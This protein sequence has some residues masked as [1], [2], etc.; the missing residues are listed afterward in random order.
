MLWLILPSARERRQRCRDSDAAQTA[1]GMRGLR[2]REPSRDDG[3]RRPTA[4]RCPPGS[5][6]L[7]IRATGTAL[8]SF[9]LCLPHAFAHVKAA[10][11]SDYHGILR[12]LKPGDRILLAPGVY[13]EG[14]TLDGL[15]GTA[16]SPIVIE[17]PADGYARFPARSNRNVVSLRSSSHIVIRNLFIDLGDTSADAVKAERSRIELRHIVLENLTII[18][19]G[20]DQ[21]SVGISTKAPAT[22]WH[23]RD[24]LIMGVG[25]G[26]YLGDS[27]GGAP[28]VGGIVERNAILNT[29]GYSLQIK[30]QVSR[31]ESSGTA[32]GRRETII[33]SNFF[34]KAVGGSTGPAARPNVL[35]GHLPLSGKDADDRY[36]I[37]GNVF[38]ANP[39]EALFQGEGNITLRSNLLLNPAGPGINVLPHNAFP[40]QIEIL[41]NFVVTAG[42]PIRVKGVHP[43]FTPSVTLNRIHRIRSVESRDEANGASADWLAFLAAL[44]ETGGAGRVAE[45]RAA[46][47]AACGAARH[48][49]LQPPKEA[50]IPVEHFTCTGASR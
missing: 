17:G 45:L 39:G 31:R 21:Q 7:S 41:G 23:I 1:L 20:A 47:R 26:V 50:L 46:L 22:S 24:N 14:L 37:S 18:G 49:H 33:R 19:R 6:S 11:P 32:A 5:G 42:E 43:D 3:A 35:I 28:F 16:R 2:A 36:L 10:N 38:F 27:D 40:R 34:S 29:R 13:T 48:G 12:D 30:H 25:T 9:A 8:I 15:R 4:V 44:A